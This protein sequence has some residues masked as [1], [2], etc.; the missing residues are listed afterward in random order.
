MPP[1][2]EIEA[3]QGIKAITSEVISQFR[4]HRKEYTI[5]FIMK[6]HSATPPPIFPPEILSLILQH[7][8]S[9]PQDLRHLWTTCRLVS[10]F[11]RHEI[12][13]IFI[14]KYLPRILLRS[15]RICRLLSECQ[16]Q[17]NLLSYLGRRDWDVAS[18]DRLAQDPAKAV[19]RR[20]D[21]FEFTRI[22]GPNSNYH[23]FLGHSLDIEAPVNI[24]RVPTYLRDSDGTIE[25][26]WKEIF[27]KLFA[28][29]R[30]R[31]HT[32]PVQT[33]DWIYKVTHDHS[34]SDL[35]GPTGSRQWFD[36]Y[37]LGRCA[38]THQSAAKREY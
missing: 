16:I 2:L 9:S 34:T 23:V 26:S 1:P 4:E 24:E 15:S 25:V 19:F 35:A 37:G 14:S 13:H 10:L 20:I 5:P 33:A 12:E 38:V 21:L 28:R 32:W 3:P 22:L 29:S 30:G 7:F 8:N 6:N 18:F 11:F 36:V 27:A 31:Q 17:S